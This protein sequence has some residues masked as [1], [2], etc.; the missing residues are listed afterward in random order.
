M[1]A[2][3]CMSVYVCAQHIHAS[4]SICM[5]LC[6]CCNPNTF[7]QETIKRWEAKT[8]LYKRSGYQYSRYD[9]FPCHHSGPTHDQPGTI[10]GDEHA[11]WNTIMP[12]YT[13]TNIYLQTK[14]HWMQCSWLY[15]NW[16]DI[17]MTHTQP[18]S[19]NVIPTAPTLAASS[20]LCSITFGLHR[21]YF[22]DMF[23][24]KC[25]NHMNFNNFPKKTK[26]SL[27]YTALIYFLVVFDDWLKAL[28]AK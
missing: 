27:S 22:L 19:H 4:N 26:F 10:C 6:V 8:S 25:W 28:C 2:C 16:S 14:Q 15:V 23:R 18:I 12:F 5:L 11:T 21:T 13:Y 24:L 20:L 17:E 7:A 3:M 1:S 9:W